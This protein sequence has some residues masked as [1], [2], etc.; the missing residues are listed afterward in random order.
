M[1]AVRTLVG[2]V[3]AATLAASI[4]G[5]TS[6]D[7]GAAS[8]PAP[9]AS[10]SSASGTP[11]EPVS[12]ELAVYG[13]RQRTAVYEKILA[14]FAEERPEI[15]VRLT[16]Y[17]DAE[18]AADAVERSLADGSGPDVFLLDPAYLPRFVT[19]EQLEPLDTLLEDRG[20][21][22]GDDYQR[23]ALTAF[24][25]SSRLQCMP[26][27]MSPLVVYYN[28]ALV[29]RQRLAAQGIVLPR[30]EETWTWDEFSAAARQ[31][32]LTDGFGPVKGVYLP[33]DLESLTAFV[34]SGGGE[35]V[36]DVFEPT[37]LTLTSDDALTTIAEVIQLAREDHVAALGARGRDAAGGRPVRRGPAR[38]V[39]RHPR[40]AAEAAE[41]RRAPLR[42]RLAAVL[43]PLPLGVED[44]RLCIDARSKS[45]DAAADL[46][47]FAVGPQASRIAA[48]SARSFRR[49]SR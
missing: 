17:P 22:F 25:A 24:S 33:T 39:H 28:R 20:L 38:D 32:A 4:A 10:S 2:V 6:R 18:S 29:S 12:L 5:C 3:A 48:R 21:Q 8:E 36:D 31:A 45:V 37:S 15:D 35:V 19:E 1:A 16:S 34:R 46:V 30:E 13:G 49:T 27:E 14:A 47:A 23:A 42:H 44:G 43:R 41:G 7:P 26:T 11:T 9:S 40:G